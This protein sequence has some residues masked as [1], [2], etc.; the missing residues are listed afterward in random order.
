MIGVFKTSSS[1][2]LAAVSGFAPS[3]LQAVLV[4]PSGPA[5]HP[6]ALDILGPRNIKYIF[7]RWLKNVGVTDGRVPPHLCWGR[8]PKTSF[9][10][11]LICRGCDRH[12][13]G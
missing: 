5:D 12:P 6:P 1:D 10:V 3:P 9:T 4:L 7:V 8:R 13:Q 11:D 2:L